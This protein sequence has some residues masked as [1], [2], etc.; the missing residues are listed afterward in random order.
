MCGRWD[1][2]SGIELAQ[3]IGTATSGPWF[4]LLIDGAAA[5]N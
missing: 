1:L 2:D 5:D 3:K 4:A